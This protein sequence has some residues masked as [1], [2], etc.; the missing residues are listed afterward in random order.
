MLGLYLPACVA[1]VVVFFEMGP[2]HQRLM[3]LHRCGASPDPTALP[4]KQE[5]VRR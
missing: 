1:S 5:A 4:Q 2:K 3:F